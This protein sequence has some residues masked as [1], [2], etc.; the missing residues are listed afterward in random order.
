MNPEQFAKKIK[1]KYPQYANYDDLELTNKIINK[2]PQ[3]RNVVELPKP[4]SERVQDIEETISRVSSSLGERADKIAEIKS[5]EASGQQGAVRSLFQKIGQGAGAVSDVIG[6]T[7]IGLGKAVLSQKAEEKIASTVSNVVSDPEFIGNLPEVQNILN[8]YESLKQTN[9]SLARDID[10]SLGLGQ[11][12]LDIATAGIGGQA[13]KGGAKLAAKGVETASQGAGKVAK[14]T[15]RG[16][17]EI[18]GALTGTS[19]ETL[20]QAF[21]SAFRGGEELN[22]FTKALRGELT[23]E[24]LVQNVRNSIDVVDTRKTTEYSQGLNSIKNIPVTTEDLIS[25]ATRKLEEFNITINPDNTL[26]FSKSNLRTV[27]AAQ[28]KLQSA[29]EELLRA[30]NS[31]NVGEIDTSRKALSE[32]LLA[33]EDPSARAANAIITDFKDQVRGVGVKATEDTGD[34]KRL[35]DNFGDDAEFLNEL[36]RSLASGDKN[37]V[38]TAYRRLA[39]SLKTNNERRMNLI[40][41]LDEATGG[42]ILADI[43][44]QQLSEAL[45]RGLFRQI[46]AGVAGAGIVTG[47]ITPGIIP[48]LVFAS[49]KVAGEV[50][51]SLGIGAKKA[52][53]IIK[54]I[55]DARKVVDDLN[56]PLPAASAVTESIKTEQQ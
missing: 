6:Q 51:R 15:G 23:P 29:Y 14:L 19:A 5:A 9:P 16:I 35:L 34:Y 44:G 10:A 56:I 21:S 18:E 37:T 25:G 55:A 32:L 42:Y 45:P 31:V 33:G 47:G 46:A 17:A 20:E 24:Q 40:R 36:K 3:Y 43:S 28:T 4:K 12:G 52:D 8:K 53:T 50:I 48:A 41:E 30:N 7:A 54:A 1:E 39:T 26:N 11:L 27:P 22:K 38:D 2:Y 49:P 13:V